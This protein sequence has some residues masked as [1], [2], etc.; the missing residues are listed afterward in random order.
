MIVR[1]LLTAQWRQKGLEMKPKL[2]LVQYM[3]PMPPREAIK[4]KEVGWT[5]A[6][7]VLLMGQIFLELYDNPEYT[8]LFT[9]VNNETATYGSVQMDQTILVLAAVAAFRK[10]SDRE[11]THR[12]HIKISKGLTEWARYNNMARSQRKAAATEAALADQSAHDDD[13]V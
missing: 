3:P 12:D 1:D 11:I 13:A 8:P 6:I 5:P 10:V 9:G 7:V 2:S 4:T